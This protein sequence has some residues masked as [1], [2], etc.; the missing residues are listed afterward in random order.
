MGLVGS[1]RREE[2]FPDDF[3]VGVDFEDTG[4][5]RLALT[6]GANNGV[7]VG[8]ALAAT[9][10]GETAVDIVVVHAPRDPAVGGEFYGF[11]AVGEIG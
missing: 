2:E 3:L 7:A 11:V 4:L 10:V 1:R 8:E 9:G 6:V 5:G